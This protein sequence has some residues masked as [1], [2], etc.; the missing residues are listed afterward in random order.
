MTKTKTPLLTIIAS[1]LLIL[2]W[3]L[4]IIYYKS[5]FNDTGNGNFIS[6]ALGITLTILL[7]ALFI[8]SVFKHWG[9]NS[10]KI[11]LLI[12]SA[13]I[14]FNGQLSNY[15]D[16]KNANSEETAIEE[17]KQSLFEEYT[18]DIKTL[19][20]TIQSKND[21]LPKDLKKRAYLATN[22]VAPLLKEIEGLKID[23]KYYELLRAEII[24]TLSTSKNTEIKNLSSYELL[25][26]NLGINSPTLL[27]LIPMVLLSLLIALTAPCGMIILQTVYP[28]PESRGAIGEG[29]P[30]KETDIKRVNT[31]NSKPDTIKNTE[32]LK[33]KVTRD[34]VLMYLE[35]WGN[36]ELPTVLKS[37]STVCADTGLSTS[38]FNSITAKARKL[39]LIESSGNGSSPC[40]RKSEFLLMFKNNS[41]VKVV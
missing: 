33:E 32:R 24:P 1:F 27:E 14:T 37:R 2:G 29:I 6:Y 35:R 16:S 34:S 18:V 7:S 10:L 23:L 28:Q 30:E 5:G 40:V 8:K 25:A 36:E 20:N 26:D 3:S 31:G 13:F 41:R 22:G 19:K 12:Y 17:N 9:W 15:N 39:G 21:L 11:V 38:V 4:D